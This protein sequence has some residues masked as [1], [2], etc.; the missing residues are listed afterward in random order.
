MEHTYLLV[1][2]ISLTLLI[3]VPLKS[4]I[5]ASRVLSLVFWVSFT[6]GIFGMF[7]GTNKIFSSDTFEFSMLLIPPFIFFEFLIGAFTLMFPLLIFS[8]F[9]VEYLREYKHL[10]LFK[11]A[12]YGGL[13]GSI[14]VTIT[15]SST[16]FTL[17][18]FIYG[19]ISVF[20]QYY[21]TEYKRKY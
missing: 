10:E 20:I 4:K 2:L 13:A 7:I 18:A 6:N 19:F 16:K 12:F 11:L 8:A 21:F 5:S 15:F 9:I 14:F 1:Y 3:L 17:M